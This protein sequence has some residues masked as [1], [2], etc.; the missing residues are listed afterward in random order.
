MFTKARRQTYR[1][2]ILQ[3][4]AISLLTVIIVFFKGLQAGY[5]AF[6]GGLAYII[7]SI[8]LIKKTFPAKTNYR[9]PSKILTDFYMGEL[10]KLTLSFILL[11][12]LFKFIPVKIVPLIG[13]Y[14]LTCLAL[15]LTPLLFSF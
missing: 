15:L 9:P 14:I 7:P 6:L 13:G 12:L 8:F 2:L 5:S 1:I 10:I 4:T 3:L 11:L